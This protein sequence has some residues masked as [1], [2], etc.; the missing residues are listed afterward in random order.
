MFLS[1]L[2]CFRTLTRYNK[3]IVSLLI[4]LLLFNSGG[5]VFVYFQLTVYFKSLASEK[6]SQYISPENLVLFKTVKGENYKFEEFKILDDNEISYYGNLYDIYK[7]TQS[8]DTTHYYCIN[9]DNENI[10]GII[11]SDYIRNNISSSSI[12]NALKNIAKNLIT[13]ALVEDINTSNITY[14]K[15]YPFSNLQLQYESPNLEKTSPPPRVII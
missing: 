5:Y 8:G 13:Q 2:N 14:I 11:F 6:I 9:D 7:K 1:I 3:V 4:L 15:E 10:L 12:F